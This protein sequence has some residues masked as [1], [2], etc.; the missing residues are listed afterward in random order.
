M[1]YSKSQRTR[2][3]SMCTTT[4]WS[5]CGVYP[6]RQ[7]GNFTFIRIKASHSWIVLSVKSWTVCPYSQRWRFRAF[8]WSL[9]YYIET[10]GTTSFRPVGL[11]SFLRKKR[12]MGSLYHHVCPCLTPPPPKYLIQWKDFMKLGLDIM[13][14]EAQRLPYT[15]T[16]LIS[17][18]QLCKYGGPANLWGGSNTTE[19]A[20]VLPHHSKI[21]L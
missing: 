2:L 20:N 21:A 16:F 7:R 5:T 17:Y 8:L 14:S 3:E 13:P 10:L 4:N 11:L 18:Q 12:W 1:R 9:L 6:R 19:T 15:C